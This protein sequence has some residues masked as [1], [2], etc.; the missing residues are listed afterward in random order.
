MP[1]RGGASVNQSKLH[2]LRHRGQT[3]SS[4]L[5][6]VCLVTANGLQEL[7]DNRVWHSW[8][9]RFSGV[10][11]KRL[12]VLS[13][14]SFSVGDVTCVSSHLFCLRS[15]LWHGATRHIEFAIAFVENQAAPLSFGRE[16]HQACA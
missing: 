16:H 13:L 12:V 10:P 3:P 1:I 8:C 6:V 7:P 5:E 4:T 14:A 2:V 15:F 9:L 11:T